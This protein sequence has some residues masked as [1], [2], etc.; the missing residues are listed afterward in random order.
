MV[1]TGGAVPLK[2]KS[3]RDDGITFEKYMG[4]IYL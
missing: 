3:I 1:A 4:K 2:I